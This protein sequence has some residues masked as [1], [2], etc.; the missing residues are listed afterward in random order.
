MAIV[1]QLVFFLIAINNG[2]ILDKSRALREQCYA[3]IER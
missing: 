2:Q 3:I 1:C